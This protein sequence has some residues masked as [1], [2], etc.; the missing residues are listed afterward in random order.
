[1]TDEVN[2]LNWALGARVEIAQA[3]G[4]WDWGDAGM[5]EGGDVMVEDWRS[6]KG[7]QIYLGA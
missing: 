1:M 6:G 4:H 3:L 5:G 7:R 2:E